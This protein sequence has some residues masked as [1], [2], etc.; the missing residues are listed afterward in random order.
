MTI[1]SN[2]LFQIIV[3]FCRLQQHRSYKIEN[4]TIELFNNNSITISVIKV[5]KQKFMHKTD[6]CNHVYQ[7]STLC[8]YCIRQLNSKSNSSNRYS[9]LLCIFHVLNMKKYYLHIK[10]SAFEK[11][12]TRSFLKNDSTLNI[13]AFIK[14][15]HDGYLDA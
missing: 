10:H 3:C 15:D 12:V 5:G 14:N 6:P 4:N 8:V 2:L 13:N 7:R 11:K 9:Q 1:T